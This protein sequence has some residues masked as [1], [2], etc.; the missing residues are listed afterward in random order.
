MLQSGSFALKN[1][2]NVYVNKIIQL[3]TATEGVR[4]QFY[5]SGLNV[6]VSLTRNSYHTLL[7]VTYIKCCDI[8]KCIVA[9]TTKR[10]EY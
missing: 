4:M 3:T 5:H 8:V 10:S 7:S 6:Y 1:G 9:L 2:L